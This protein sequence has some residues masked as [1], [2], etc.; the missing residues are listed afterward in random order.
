MLVVQMSFYDHEE[1]ISHVASEINNTIPQFR[2]S[3]NNDTQALS[4]RKNGEPEQT[5][6]DMQ[7]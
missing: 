6:R 5:Q 4:P 1:R 7:K 2:V 3:S